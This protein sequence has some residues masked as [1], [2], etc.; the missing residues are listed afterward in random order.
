MPA[1]PRIEYRLAF[2]GS[3][4]LAEANALRARI[5]EILAKP[6]F[7]S[8]TIMFSS[9]GGSAGQ[10]LALY[11]FIIQLPVS[12]RMHAVGAVE[13]GGVTVFLSGSTRTCSP[14]SKFYFH[15]YTW[16]L[17]G[18]QTLGQL[19]DTAKRLR[20]DV[21]LAKE[22]LSARTAAPAEI[23]GTLDGKCPP[24]TVSPVDAKRFGLV[25][26]VLDLKEQGGDRTTIAVLAI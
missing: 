13:S 21:E 19:D 18:A 16:A 26:D 6:D 12:V 14:W 11:N 7:G 9:S 22:V 17:N 10:S 15:E 25:D 3:I 20:S 2:E 8:L 4:G 23:L 5:C 24:I 1:A